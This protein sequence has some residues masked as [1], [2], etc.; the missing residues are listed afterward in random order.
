MQIISTA[1]NCY[2]VRDLT[3]SSGAIDTML[4]GMRER[5]RRVVVLRDEGSQKEIY[6]H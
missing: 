3:D 1:P 5:G 6:I 2:K 4:Q